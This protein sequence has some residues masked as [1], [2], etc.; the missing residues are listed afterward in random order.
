MIKSNSRSVSRY[1]EKFDNLYIFIVIS[2]LFVHSLTYA[3]SNDELQLNNPSD[4]YVIPQSTTK[5][6]NTGQI[7]EST[8]VYAQ[9]FEY[10]DFDPFNQDL[11]DKPAWAQ[12]AYHS[13]EFNKLKPFAHEL[14][15]GNFTNT[16]QIDLNQNYRIASGD[17]VL[18]RMWGAKTFD[19]ILTVDLQGNV[20][21][22]EI[23]PVYVLGTTP[24]SLVT[25]IKLAV[26]KVFTSNV[27]LY[28]NLQ[29]SQPI[30]VFVTGQVNNPGR[31]AG[32]QNDNIL[33]YIDRAGGINPFLGSY[34]TIAIKR[35][36]KIIKMIDLYKFVT[37]GEIPLLRLNN[38]DVIVVAN[39]YMSVSAYGLV[40]RPA[41]Y[42]F[43]LSSHKGKD[44][45]KLVSV[46]PSVTHVQISGSKDGIPFNKYLDLSSFVNYD[47]NADDRIMFISDQ[48]KN[49]ILTSVIG[50]IGSKSRFILPKGSRLK[51]VLKNIQID[52]SITD[53]K[54][55]YIKRK[56]VANQQKIII[57]Q[58][59]KRLEESSLL[60]ESNSV[61]EANIRVKEAQLVQDFVKRAHEIKPDGVVVVSINGNI[62]DILLED[63]DE[64]IIPQKTD[65]VQIGGEVI[66]PKAVIFDQSFSIDDYINQGGGYT[67]RANPDHILIILPNGQVGTLKNLKIQPGARLVVMPKVDSKNMQFFKDI[68]QIIYQ[69]AVATKVAVGL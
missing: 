19:Q 51:A 3:S 62:K 13:F 2:C 39:K 7:E 25:T 57:D 35:N 32:S 65:V 34:R 67:Q 48:H 9:S 15:K 49:T 45:M 12:G 56:S 50:G 23:G 1:Y 37:E 60:A 66:M 5:I 21:I 61:D 31:Y 20:F 26:S 28:V 69:L 11:E 24:D 29:S 33:S 41:T 53:Y 36:G 4:R 58:A 40:R 54:S 46:G 6:G 52:P 59:L 10:A 16:Y 18:V 14:F 22:P 30:A 17:R 38:D 64:I 43:T 44:L 63:H 8:N 42:E 68:M 27:E 47:L 55:V